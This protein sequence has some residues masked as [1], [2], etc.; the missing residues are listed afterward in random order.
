ME[1]IGSGTLNNLGVE[2]NPASPSTAAQWILTGYPDANLA[3]TPGA[4]AD[5]AAQAAARTAGYVL[6]P[7][8][9]ANRVPAYFLFGLNGAY[10]FSN[11]PGIKG[12]QLYTQVNN[13]FNRSPPFTGGTTSNP[14]FYDELGLAYR[15]GFRMT[16]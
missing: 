15:A 7:E 11:I 3:G 6:L 5:A 14:I 2:Y 8:N 10:T 4:P 12:L 9:V 16:F 13:V 1:F